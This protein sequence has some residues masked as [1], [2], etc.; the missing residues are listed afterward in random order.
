VYRA[1]DL[2]DADFSTS[3]PVLVQIHRIRSCGKNVSI[4]TSRTTVEV[5]EAG[6][7]C[8]GVLEGRAFELIDALPEA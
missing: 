3:D 1:F 5:S 4:P 8:V 7:L 2:A 6:R